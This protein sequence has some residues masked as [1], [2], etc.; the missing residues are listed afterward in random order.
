M[1]Y[2]EQ[3]EKRICRRMA[4]LAAENLTLE[5]IQDRHYRAYNWYY[6]MV[7]D[8][9]ERACGSLIEDKAFE[10]NALARLAASRGIVI[11]EVRI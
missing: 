10:V 5:Q 8:N 4:K 6:A 11:K 9:P 3:I 2:R 7:M 1:T